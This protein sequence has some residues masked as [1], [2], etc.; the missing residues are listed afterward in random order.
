MGFLD[1]I[2]K[3]IAQSPFSSIVS[4][5]DTIARQYTQLKSSSPNLS[6]KEIYEQIVKARYSV[7]PLKEERRYKDMLNE[8]KSTNTLARLV[9]SILI[10]ESP[11]LIKS[12][13]ENVW[14]T[15]EIIQKQLEKHNLR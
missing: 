13:S 4:T 3:K 10:N 11:D 9:L 8:I 5:S 14:M 1:N 12:G 15:I 2:M 7:I 6:D